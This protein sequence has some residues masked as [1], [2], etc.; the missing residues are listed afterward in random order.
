MRHLIHVE[1]T[2]EQLIAEAVELSEHRAQSYLTQ[3]RKD[4]ITRQMGYIF[5]ELQARNEV[6]LMGPENE[7]IPA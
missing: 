1:A 5:F 4:G 2:N 3:E 7:R 6:V